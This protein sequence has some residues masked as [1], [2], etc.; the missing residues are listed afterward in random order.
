MGNLSSC[1]GQL[2]VASIILYALVKVIYHRPQPR[3]LV[4]AGM[5]PWQGKVSMVTV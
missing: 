3:G 4:R 2:T 1:Y 5:Y